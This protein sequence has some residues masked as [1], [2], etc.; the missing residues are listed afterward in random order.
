M[1]KLVGIVLIA[2]ALFMGFIGVNKVDKSG[3]TVKFLGV[4]VS[5]QDESAK[6]TGYIYVGLA[7]ICLVGGVVMLRGK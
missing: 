5:A 3:S 6:Q 4:K 1:K 2:G 7:V